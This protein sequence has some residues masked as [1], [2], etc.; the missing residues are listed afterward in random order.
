MNTCVEHFLSEKINVDFAQTLA[1]LVDCEHV[2]S[3]DKRKERKENLSF[4]DSNVL[5]IVPDQLCK[6]TRGNTGSR[7][8]LVRIVTLIGENRLEFSC[9]VFLFRI[10]HMYHPG[11]SHTQKCKHLTGPGLTTASE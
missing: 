5:K 3:K 6:F 8:K 1:K 7:L 2:P 9:L 10:V 4:I 11:V